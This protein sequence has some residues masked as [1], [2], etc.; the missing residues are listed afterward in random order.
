MLSL[1]AAKLTTFF[2]VP[3]QGPQQQV[4]LLY[5]LE[6]YHLVESNKYATLQ[7]PLL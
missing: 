2:L 7:A 6:L 4:S 5:K 1:G 3:T